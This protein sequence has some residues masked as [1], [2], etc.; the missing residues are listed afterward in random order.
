MLPV[1]LDKQLEND[2][3]SLSRDTGLSKTVIARTSLEKYMKEL[4]ES[5]IRDGLILIKKPR[6]LV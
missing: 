4:S 2:L 6:G 1:R 3:N 5:G